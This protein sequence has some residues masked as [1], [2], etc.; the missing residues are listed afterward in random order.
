MRQWQTDSTSDPEYRILTR[1]RGETNFFLTQMLPIPIAD[2]LIA[3]LSDTFSKWVFITLQSKY[4][5][6]ETDHAEHFLFKCKRWRNYRAN[7]KTSVGRMLNRTSLVNYMLQ[8]KED[9]KEIDTY[10]QRQFIKKISET[11]Q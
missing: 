9:C 4:C 7:T 8:R 11:D 3:R 10:A 1:N 5:P 6:D 2:G